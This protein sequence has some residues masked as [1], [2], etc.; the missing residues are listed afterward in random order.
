MA[1][2]KQSKK[3]MPPRN[4]ANMKDNPVAH[5]F[6]KNDPL[7]GNFPFLTS[8]WTLILPVL[9]IAGYWVIRLINQ[10]QMNINNQPV[11]MGVAEASKLDPAEWF[12]LDVREQSE[13]NKNHIEWA[14]LISLGELSMR[15]AEL[16]KNKKIIVVC[17]SGNRSARGRDMLLR[18][19]FDSVTN[20]AGGINDWVSQ[21][22]PVVIDS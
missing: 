10:R 6:P 1:K 13:W 4:R 14:T 7:H 20:M 8:A 2:S 18:A 3:R 21:G 12:F 9:A 11:E 19:G 15:L 17:R 16:P 22:L 5:K